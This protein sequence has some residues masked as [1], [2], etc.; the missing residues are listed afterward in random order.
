MAKKKRRTNKTAPSFS[1]DYR[2]GSSAPVQDLDDTELDDF[3]P[4]GEPQ[5]DDGALAKRE[6][7]PGCCSPSSALFRLRA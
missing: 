6:D 5:P 7:A 2:T 4:D 3:L 1:A